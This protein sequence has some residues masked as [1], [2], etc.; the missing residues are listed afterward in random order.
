MR[1]NCRVL[2]FAASVTVLQLATAAQSYASSVY[3]AEMRESNNEMIE[4]SA[5]GSNIVAPY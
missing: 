5:Y 1:K 3:A 4:Y 2:L